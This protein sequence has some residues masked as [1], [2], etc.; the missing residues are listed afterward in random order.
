MEVCLYYLGSSCFQSFPLI[1]S[2]FRHLLFI[3]FWSFLFNSE[4]ILRMNGHKFKPFIPMCEIIAIGL[5][6]H[7]ILGDRFFVFMGKEEKSLKLYHF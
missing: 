5:P 1:I 4:Y 7:G 6:V 2:T 3:L